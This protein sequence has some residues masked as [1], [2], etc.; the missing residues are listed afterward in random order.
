[1]TEDSGR[2][3]FMGLQTVRHDW[4]TNFHFLW[5]TL[6]DNVYIHPCCCKWQLFYSFIYYLFLVKQI[7][8]ILSRMWD[9]SSPS[10][11]EPVPFAVEAWSLNHCITRDVFH[12]F[13]WLRVAVCGV[14]QSR[15]WLKRLSSSSSSSKNLKFIS[16]Q[17]QIIDYYKVQTSPIQIQL[18]IHL[19]HTY[20][21]IL[22]S[23]LRNYILK[24]KKWGFPD[25][26]VVEN[27][28]ANTGDTGSIPTPGRSY[29]PSGN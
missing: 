5:F 2:L 28:P 6:Y 3:Q 10:G 25:S 11:I 21:K 12:S 1:M 20:R 8:A 16:L 13:L 29:M 14:A 27:L 23:V 9:L 22:Y 26:P 17:V 7:L 15:T 19:N 18:H 4:E 24:Q